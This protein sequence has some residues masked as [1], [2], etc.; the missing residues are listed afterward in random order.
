LEN[1]NEYSKVLIFVDSKKKADLVFEKLSEQLT[2]RGI[3]IDRL[4][5]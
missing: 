3:E 1:N 2:E 5:V 4:I